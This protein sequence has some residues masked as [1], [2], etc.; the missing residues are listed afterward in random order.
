MAKRHL[1]ENFSKDWGGGLAITKLPLNEGVNLT[2]KIE[3]KEYKVLEG[4]EVP[5]WRIG[6]KN[7]NERVYS[8]RLAEKVINEFGSL[9]TANLSDHPKEEGSV[10]DILSV[11]KNPHIRGG[12]LYVDSYIV[13]EEFGKKLKKMN[14]VGYG[15]GVSSSCYGDLNESTGE[16]LTEGFEVDRFFDWVLTPSYQVYVDESC[17]KEF[18]MNESNFVVGEIMS[19][20]LEENKDSI[21]NKV[22]SDKENTVMAGKLTSLEEKNLKLGIKA[23]FEKASTKDSLKEKLEVYNEILEYCEGVEFA[24]EY[25]TE[26]NS[27]IAEITKKLDE[28]AEKGK[29]A[30]KL[31][32]ENTS[33]SEAKTVAESKI[34]ETETKLTEMKENYEKAI[35]ML[36][37]F[38]V[39]ETRLKEMYDIV[40]AEK[41]GMIEASEYKELADKYDELE[42]RIEEVITENNNYS[43]LIKA[44]KSKIARLEAEEKD[45][46]D[47]EEKEEPKNENRKR[48][49][50]MRR[51]IK[52]SE[53]EDESDEES[54]DD[55]DKEEK[56]EESRRIRR[57]YHSGSLREDDEEDYDLTET[58]EIESYINELLENNPANKKIVKALRSCK[59]LFEAQTMYLSLSDLVESTP[60]P[61][62]SRKIAEGTGTYGGVQ[63]SDKS[64]RMNSLLRPGWQ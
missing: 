53:E 59:T 27:N 34:A 49:V 24:S 63:V 23:L 6:V 61:F 20:R 38:K 29:K 4:Y 64:P 15:L 62:R 10:S 22:A 28:L 18:V 30:D 17:K 21:T 39:R 45:E 19:I 51:K 55:E 32:E 8:Q 5:V 7:L 35:G 1:V 12:I 31:M 54:E 58:A 56:K 40:V 9:V 57:A 26:A 47:D 25:V 41:N 3:G 48:G 16:V 42:E 11:A 37:E 2:E 36:D 13:D 52:E 14:E 60:S 46:E 50:S 33:L 43:K 44:Y